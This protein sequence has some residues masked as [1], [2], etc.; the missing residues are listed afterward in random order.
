MHQRPLVVAGQQRAQL[1]GV[2][3]ERVGER[4]RDPSGMRVR[5][6]EV[7]DRVGVGGRRELGDP[8]LLVARRDLAQHA[9]DETGTRRIEFDARLLDGGVDGG[10]R[11]DPGAQQLVGAE[12]Q[13]VEQHRVDAVRSAGPPPQR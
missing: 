9:V 10:V 2:G 1:A 4:L 12:P 7:A 11:F 3:T 5:E 6:G 8:R 13:Q